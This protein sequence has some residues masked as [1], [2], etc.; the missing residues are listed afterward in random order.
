MRRAER[1]REHRD[2]ALV[3]RRRAHLD[4]GRE[5]DALADDPPLD[6]FQGKRRDLVRRGPERYTVVVPGR[7]GGGPEIDPS[8]VATPAAA[9]V[10]ASSAT[11]AGAIALR[12]ANS[13][14]EAAGCAATSSATSRAAPGGTTERTISLAASSASSEP[15]SSRPASVARRRDRS[16]R[17]SSATTTVAPPSRRRAPRALPHLAR[18]DQPDGHRAERSERRGRMTGTT[19]PRHRRRGTWWLPES[20]GRRLPRLDIEGEA[21]HSEA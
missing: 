17:P 8:T 14:P 18:T 1:L 13:R 9:S 11:P 7:C 4:G 19:P 12:S 3:D 20:L 2:P 15:T 6:A 21:Q 5:P 16:D 10:S